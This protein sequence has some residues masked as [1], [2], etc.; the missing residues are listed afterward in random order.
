MSK[1]TKKAYALMATTALLA[2]QV[3]VV[4]HAATEAQTSITVN[5]QGSKPLSEN[6][7]VKMNADQV[8]DLFD[9]SVY[10]ARSLFSEEGQKGWDYV[11]QTLLNFDS[12]DKSL[13]LTTRA[14]GKGKL[15]ID[16]EAAGI[17]MPAS[18]AALLNKYIIRSEA[19]MFLIYDWGQEY[20]QQ[21]GIAKTVTYYIDPAMMGAGA[22]Q[23]T[24]MKIEQT[25]S[26]ILS[27]VDKEMDTIQALRAAYDEYAKHVKYANVT[28]CGNIQGA[29]ITGNVICGGYAKGMLYLAHRLGVEALWTDG[30]AGG[31]HAWNLVNINDGWYRIDSTWDDGGDYAGHNHFLKGVKE[32]TV[33]TAYNPF[34][35]MPTQAQESIPLSWS[36]FPN[37]KVEAPKSINIERGTIFNAV[38]VIK[39]TDIYGYDLTK[40]IKVVSNN[41]NTTKNGSYEVTYEVSDYKGHTQQIT[42]PV[43]VVAKMV[44]ASDVEWKSST[45]SYTANQKDKSIAGQTIKLFNGTQVQEF[46]KGLGVHALSEIVYDV[47]GRGF[48][49]FEA[50][51]GAERS[52]ATIGGNTSVQYKV[53]VDGVEKYTSEIMR[54]G[55]PM[56]FVS[57]E[58]KNAKE[59]KLVMN[60]GGNGIG[61]DH[62]AWA[63][64]KFI[65]NTG[66]PVITVSDK[67]YSLGE[68]VDLQSLATVT[69]IEDGELIASF[70]TD[71][72]AGQT[73]VFDVVYTA[74]DSDGNISSEAIQ[75]Y[76]PEKEVYASDTEWQSATVGWLQATK[77][78]NISGNKIR[79]KVGDDVQTFNKGI[80]AHAP[81]EVVYDLTTMNA[82]YFTAYAGVDYSQAGTQGNVKFN[83]YVDGQLVKDTNA[84]TPESGAQFI[85]VDLRGAKEL[86]LVADSNGT[87]SCDHAIWADAK[88]YTKLTEL[89]KAK[90]NLQHM[91]D[92]ALNIT[93][94]SFVN[95][96]FNHKDTRLSNLFY[97]IETSKAV[98][99]KENGTLQDYKNTLISL[100]YSIEEVG[101]AYAYGSEPVQF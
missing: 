72:K 23:N 95:P 55:T 29:F 76:V 51:V 64:A 85:N 35:V 48:D 28:N 93:D 20:T 43:N 80:G 21:N 83:V 24:L 47:S 22:Y 100:Q 68:D 74:V 66:V 69:D 25:V 33:Y 70:D 56:D 65:T 5:R 36:E 87:A 27:K 9:S 62:G 79:L 82:E 49:R 16:L 4:A 59:I 53:Y 86:K 41:V 18:E 19:R 98:L 89:E 92:Y 42:I 14:D 2:S 46:K 11:L 77:D 54:P 3:T 99:E 30:W 40:E 44:Y 97:M 17:K 13:N 1:K 6:F 52:T 61:S 37:I 45:G 12:D 73:G 39:A 96:S 81:S 71:Y 38:D 58:V 91:Y 10:Y 15:T 26:Q 94:L 88:F 50:Y 31:Y 75:I 8:N 32:S 67:V 34:N 57:V 7:I 101:Q 84:V 78:T 60:D 90:D 63:D